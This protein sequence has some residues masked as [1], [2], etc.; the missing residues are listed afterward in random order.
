MTTISDNPIPL[1]AV[2][3]ATHKADEE[4]EPHKVASDESGDSKTAAEGDV[5][6]GEQEGDE[7]GKEPDPSRL[8]TGKKLILVSIALVFSIF[9]VS[10]DQTILAPALGAPSQPKLASHFNSLDKLAWIESAYLLTQIPFM[11][12]WAQALTVFDR[13]KVFLVTIAWFEVGSLIGGSATDVNVLI[14]GRAVS[15][16]GAAG[17]YVACLAIIADVATMKTRPVIQGVFGTFFS[18]S[19]VVGP[20]LG[21]V[22]TDHV[23]WRLCFYSTSTSLLF[24]PQF[25]LTSSTTVNLPFGVL[26]ILAV[27]FLI[28]PLPAPPITEST[29][30]YT[31]RKIARW[32][33]GRWTP[34]SSSFFFHLFVLD[35]I[36]ATLLLGTVTALVLPLQWAGVRYAWSDPRI[37]GTLCT[38]GALVPLFLCYE[39]WLAG[40]TCVLPLRL[41]KNRTLIGSFLLSFWLMLSLM[42]AIFYLP[43][44]F[45]AT[46][47]VSA[48]KSALYLLPLTF[49]MLLVAVL[50]G[51]LVS[52]IGYYLHILIIGPFF[53]CISCGLLY[54][55]TETTP[56]AKV[57]GYCCI[58]AIGVG[59]VM[60][61]AVIAVQADTAE[62]KDIPQTTALVSFSHI[63]GGTVGICIASTIFSAS[64]IASLKKYA[65]GVPSALVRNSV[66]TIRELP[67][68]EQ[69]GVIKAYVRAIQIVFLVGA[70]TGVLCSLSSMICR[71]RSVKG[72]S[73]TGM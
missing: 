17:I 11:L 34:S 30:A 15:G 65:P 22:F 23:T 41:F 33:R 73:M 55:I 69:A 36:G 7:K 2:D 39:L 62:K 67:L 6:Q 40:E 38:F 28:N 9:L 64:L 13:K 51:I 18:A 42:F 29:K 49:A 32:T 25:S 43:V 46:R 59:S 56:L 37:I 12:L 58:L 60:Q 8:V 45:Q 66:T 63:L 48:T 52:K 47:G 31:E 44:F 54:T 21:G 61:N 5:E 27:V 50:A 24:V 4:G 35:W 72:M 10:L 70:G 1:Q 3:L 16:A 14:F 26:S 20:I 53:I 57:L 19:A 68:E 71:N